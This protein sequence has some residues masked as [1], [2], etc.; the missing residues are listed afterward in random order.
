MNENN[1]IQ[2]LLCKPKLQILES[3]DVPSGPV[4]KNPPC[5]AEEAG[6]VPDWETKIPH[7][8]QQVSPRATTVETMHHNR[9]V[10]ELRGR[11]H[12]LPLRPDTAKFF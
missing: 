4:V 5:S 7:A 9:R 1:C 6:S 12:T 2:S 11:F 3:G 8:T 10:H